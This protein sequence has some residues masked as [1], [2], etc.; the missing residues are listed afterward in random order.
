M[1]L[2]SGRFALIASE[3][4]KALI[5]S[6]LLDIEP[7][8]IEEAEK[9][10]IGVLREY[11]RMDRELSQRAR[12]MTVG[13]GRGA[14][15]RSKRRL[16]KDKNFRIGDDSLEYIVEQMIEVFL[17][18]PSIEEIYGDDR[19]LR[20]K[21]TPVVKKH[22]ASQDDEVDVEVRSKIKNLQEGSTAW[23]VEYERALNRVKRNRGLEAEE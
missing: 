1:R 3:L 10:V 4:V 12:D 7:E 21:I 6:E 18:S 2:Y 19:E 20:S 22:T 11:Q 5:D 15:L 23:E 16:A 14:E 13:E 9:D 8:K 17:A